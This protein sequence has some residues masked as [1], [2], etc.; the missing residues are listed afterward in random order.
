MENIPIPII[1]SE[2]SGRCSHS[3]S[4]SNIFDIMENIERDIFVNILL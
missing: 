1:E 2:D 3:Y 4:Y